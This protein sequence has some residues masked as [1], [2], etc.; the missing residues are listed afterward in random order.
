MMTLETG[1]CPIS[2]A[3]SFKL[4]RVQSREESS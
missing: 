1:L 3:A 4:F 2:A